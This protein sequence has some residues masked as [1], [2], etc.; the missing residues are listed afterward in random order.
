[1]EKLF[2]FVWKHRLF[3]VKPMKTTDGQDVEV[4]YTGLHNNDA[5][6]DFFNAQVKIDGQLWVGNVELHLKASDWMKHGHD[7]D[8][9]YDNVVVHVVTEADTDVWNTK[10]QRLPQVVVPIPEWLKENYEQLLREDRYPRCHRMIPEMP[11]LTIHAWMAALQTERLER[12]TEDVMNRVKECNGAWEEAFFLTLARNYGFGVN[13]DAFEMWARSFDLHMVARHRDDLF[14]IEAFFIGQ[15]GLLDINAAPE[16]H[17]EAMENDLYYQ[18]LKS[19]YRYLAHRFQLTPIDHKMWKFMRMRPQNFPYIRLSQLA[20]LYYRTR[21]LMGQLVDCKDVK[22]LR[23]AMKTKVSDYWQTHYL[24][25][26]ESEKNE[27]NMS[28]ASLDILLINTVI[29]LLFAYGR[30]R[31]NEALVEKAVDMLEQ[32]KPEDNNIVRL[33]R[34]CGLD[35]ENAGDS[36]ALIQLKKEYCDKKE[37]LRCRIGREFMKTKQHPLL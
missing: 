1:M 6:P 36:Q 31:R 21:R 13:S 33:W 2:H 14:Q 7:R 5:G 18:R 10:G 17:R 35:V 37:C 25:G 26:V 3:P 11:R 30:Y 12:K 28:D 27:K 8:E 23:E 29:P 24:F 22:E 4:L 16:Q 34:E 19:E 9:K 15:A 20:Y 32:L